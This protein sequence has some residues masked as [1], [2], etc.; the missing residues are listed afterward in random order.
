MKFLLIKQS[1]YLQTTHKCHSR[2]ELQKGWNKNKVDWVE[3]NVIIDSCTFEIKFFFFL[4]A[5]NILH[6]F[7]GTKHFYK[8][9]HKK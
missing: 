9:K 7:W 2:D 3:R 8:Y 1:F 5:S 6:D 4:N